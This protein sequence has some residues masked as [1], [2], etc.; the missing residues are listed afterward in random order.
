MGISRVGFFYLGG[1]DVIFLIFTVN[2]DI[3]LEM[4][5]IFIFELTVF[6]EGVIVELLRVVVVIIVVNDD[7][8]GVFSFGEVYE[9]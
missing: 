2:D 7:V 3:D 6:S 9:K 4:E 1:F 5:E 8:Y